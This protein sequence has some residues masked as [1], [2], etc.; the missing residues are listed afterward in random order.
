[1]RVK[2]FA[3][4]FSM[5]C[6]VGSIGAHAQTAL[7]GCPYLNGQFEPSDTDITGCAKSLLNHQSLINT[8]NSIAGII[9]DR[10]N[11]GPNQ[12]EPAGLKLENATDILERLTGNSDITIAPTADI[13]APTLSPTW[14]FWVDGKY[15]WLDDTS[16]FSN[17]DGS[18]INL[19]LGADYKFTDRLVLG[20]TPPSRPASAR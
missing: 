10:F 14:N 17:L 15:S 1:M 5:A 6:I 4:T 19:I 11:T 18:L 16:A 12:I 7:T 2:T 3:A 20:L 8:S 13:V 9:G